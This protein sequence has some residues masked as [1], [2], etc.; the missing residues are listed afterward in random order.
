[1]KTRHILITFVIAAG[2]LIVSLCAQENG[3]DTTPPKKESE[4]VEALFDEIMT[5]LPGELKLQLD[6]LKGKRLVPADG[7]GKKKLSDGGT[8]E[9]TREEALRLRQNAVEGLSPQLREKV[10]ALIKE[11]ERKREE[12]EVEFKQMRRQNIPQ[13]KKKKK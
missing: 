11:M 5:T 2:A 1:M 8:V 4:T 13:T 12:R 6:S 9:L 3:V 7:S 10:E